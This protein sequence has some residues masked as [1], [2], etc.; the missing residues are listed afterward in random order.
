MIFWIMAI[1]G[2]ID[3]V[4]DCPSIGWPMVGIM[5]ITVVALNWPEKKSRDDL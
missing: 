2:A 5:A 4:R 1:S 3:L